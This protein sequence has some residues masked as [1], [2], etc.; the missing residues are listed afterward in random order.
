MVLR[1]IFGSNER[2]APEGEKI[3]T[4]NFA[5]YLHKIL[6]RQWYGTQWDGWNRD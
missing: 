6:L 3:S 1:K 2:E 5:N 4:R